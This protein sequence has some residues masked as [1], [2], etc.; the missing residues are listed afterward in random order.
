MDRIQ[1]LA[2]EY[3]LTLD[4]T[5]E[6]APKAPIKLGNNYPW[7]IFCGDSRHRMF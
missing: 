7:M 4:M 6:Q 2:T 5:K 1:V 3:F